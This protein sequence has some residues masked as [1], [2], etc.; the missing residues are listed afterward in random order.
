MWDR[1]R[2]SLS[3]TRGARDPFRHAWK[4]SSQRGLQW[5]VFKCK[6]LL[7]ACMCHLLMSVLQWCMAK[8][9]WL[10]W[11]YAVLLLLLPCLNVISCFCKSFPLVSVWSAS[12]L[13]VCIY[14][15]ITAGAEV[16]LLCILQMHWLCVLCFMIGPTCS[17]V[18]V[19]ISCLW[20][21]RCF[22]QCLPLFSQLSVFFCWSPNST[23]SYFK[24]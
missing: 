11:L 12:C 2:A 8:M 7:W 9:H 1:Q 24:L 3:S 19:T 17:S 4:T 21:D 6:A 13:C 14:F 16:L 15:W 22:S 18:H 20:N 10:M 5:C 23:K